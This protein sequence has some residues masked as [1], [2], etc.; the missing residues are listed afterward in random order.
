MTTTSQLRRRLVLQEINLILWCGKLALMYGVVQPTRH[1][2]A[3]FPLSVALM[4][5]AMLVSDFCILV[6]EDGAQ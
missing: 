2:I 6:K 4:N 3:L 1:W 5:V